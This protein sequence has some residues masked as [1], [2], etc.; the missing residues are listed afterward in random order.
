MFKV[1]PFVALLALCGCAY[2]PAQLRPEFE[3]PEAFSQ[4]TQQPIVIDA[5]WWQSFQSG[6]LSGL[7]TK[8]TKS[9]LTLSDAQLRLSQAQ[10]QYQ[11]S[12]ADDLPAVTA[13]ASGR[14]ARDLDTSTQQSSSSAG[15]GVSYDFDIWGSREA[16]Q[17]AAELDVDVAQEQWR[18]AALQ[19]QASLATHYITMLSLQQRRNIARQNVEASEKL[20]TLINV[21]YQAGD[22]SGIEVAQ[23]RNTLLAAKAEL[24]S[25]ENNIV[26]RNRQIAALLGDTGFSARD[27]AADINE[28]ALPNITI[29]QPASIIAQKPEVKAALK[30]WQLADIDVYQASIAGLPG[31]SFSASLS[32][33]DLLTLADGWSVSGALSS[34]ATLFD[35]DKRALAEAVNR[36]S[37]SIAVNNVKSVTLDAT[38][39]LL[40]SLDSYRYLEQAYQLDL[41]E[42]DNNRR[43]YQLSEIRYKSG[44]TD[45]LTLLNAQRSWFSAQLAVVN[46]YRDLLIGSVDVYL[47][48]GG[49]PKLVTP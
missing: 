29:S 6:E 19:M 43:L 35:N 2:S 1:V 5:Q 11:R 41:Q 44:D 12:H 24:L 18:S 14:S 28:L 17:L 31:L 13:S 3:A 39:T 30:Q 34:A 48:A 47:A 26:L 9:N 45:F 33:S 40:D 46:S 38:Q 32:L 42:L 7:M 49:M 10:L 23:Q 25:I 27:Y 21:R 22:T 37:L 15:L 36:V 4:Y 8:L 16:E 20:L